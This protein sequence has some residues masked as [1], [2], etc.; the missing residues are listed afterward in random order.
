MPTPPTDTLQQRLAASYADSVAWMRVHHVRVV[1]MSW[2]N[3]PSN[4]ADV[5]EKNGIGKTAEERK[6]LARHYFTIERDGLYA[7]L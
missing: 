6:A 3:R 5:L 7:A 1:N 4:Y 2:W